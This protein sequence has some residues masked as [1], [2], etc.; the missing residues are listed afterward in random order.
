MK[1][2]LPLK[3][4]KIIIDT[5]NDAFRPEPQDEIARILTE[6]GHNIARTRTLEQPIRDIK[7]KKVGKLQIIGCKQEEL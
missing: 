4:V 3:C 1:K 5:D 6:L 7:G 2:T